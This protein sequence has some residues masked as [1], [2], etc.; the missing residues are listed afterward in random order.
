MTFFQKVHFIQKCSVTQNTVFQYVKNIF[1][2]SQKKLRFFTELNLCMMYD[3]GYTIP[4]GL[5]LR[6]RVRRG[7]AGHGLPLLRVHAGGDAVED[8]V[9]GQH[10]QGD[11]GNL[12]T[13][14]CR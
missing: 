12:A 1:L 8:A 11:T 5:L 9:Q 13:W 7:G 4:P 3:S 2:F 14:D 10:E 6:P